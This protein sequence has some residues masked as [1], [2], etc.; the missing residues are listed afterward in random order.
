MMMAVIAA[1]V[2]VFPT[3]HAVFSEAAQRIRATFYGCAL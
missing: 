3:R 2:L 1:M